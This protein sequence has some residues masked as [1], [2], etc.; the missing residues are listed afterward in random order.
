MGKQSK[1]KKVRKI[2]KEM[3]QIIEEALETGT[4]VEDETGDFKFQ[5]PE[6][7]GKFFARVMSNPEIFEEFIEDNPEFLDR[8]ID[9]INAQ[10]IRAADDEDDEDDEELK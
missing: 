10:D 3:G 2:R 8:I 6:L 1:L 4:L 7:A 5:D 9:I